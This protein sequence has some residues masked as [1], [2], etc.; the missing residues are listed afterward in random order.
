MIKK[1]KALNR[2]EFEAAQSN[3]A[4]YGTYKGLYVYMELGRE[5]EYREHPKDDPNTSYKLFRQCDIEYSETSDQS[6][7]GDYQ[8]KDTQVDVILYW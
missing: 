6:K 1:I 8:Y 3:E 2:L 5:Q 4:V 7:N